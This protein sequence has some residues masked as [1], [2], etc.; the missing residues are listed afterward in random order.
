MGSTNEDDEWVVWEP[1]AFDQNFLETEVAQGHEIQ[2]HAARYLN[3]EVQD[4]EGEWVTFREKFA[5]AKVN[6]LI[7]SL[8]KLWRSGWRLSTGKKGPALKQGGRILPMR[9]RRNTLV[10]TAL[11]SSIAMLD[12]SVL[13]PQIEDVIE[14][15]RRSIQLDSLTP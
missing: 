7:I 15:A 5:I 2:Q 13:P 9:L 1:P 3:V 10:M 6:S 12:V 11:V 8:G 14:N 4:D